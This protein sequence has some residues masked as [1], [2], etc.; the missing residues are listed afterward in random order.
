MARRPMD[1]EPPYPRARD[2]GQ[3]PRLDR[4]PRADQGH[5]VEAHLPQLG[6]PRRRARDG[7]QRLGWQEPAR[8]CRQPRS[9]E[10]TS[11]LQSLMRLSYAVFCLKKKKKKQK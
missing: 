3:I 10:H 2:G 7:I 9:E 6:R 4:Q 5:G 11:E 8:A 1:V